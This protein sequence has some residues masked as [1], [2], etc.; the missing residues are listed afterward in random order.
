M[1]RRQLRPKPLLDEPSLRSFLVG[2]GVKPVHMS[3]IWRHMLANPDC[4]LDEIPGIPDRI[5]LPLKEEFTFL[6]STVATT[7]ES[8][9]DGTIKL[10][11][12]LQ[13][14]GEIE[15]VLIHHT[16]EAEDPAARQADRCG[17]RDTLCVSSQVGCRLGCTFCATGTMGLQGNLWAGEIQEQ[18]VHARRLRPVSNIVF[19]G[20]GEPLENY[21]G[22]VNAIRGLVDVQR[23]GVAPSSITVS[24]VGIVNNMRRFMDDL[25][26]IKLAISLHAP[27]QE[28]REQIVPVG[29]TFKLDALMEVLDEY[30]ERN[31]K[32]M[33]MVS[34]VLLAGVNDTDECAQQ[35]CELVKGRPVIVNLIPYNPFEENVYRYETPTDER[36][37]EFL[38][39]LSEAD[40]RVFQ[41]RHHGRDI[42][43][44]C[45]QL[46]KLGRQ[47]PV[48]DIENFTLEKERAPQA[49][50]RGPVASSRADRPRSSTS[51]G[52]H[53]T[54]LLALTAAVVCAA[55]AVV[56]ARWRGGG[57]R[58]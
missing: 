16:G 39:V 15:C 32:G 2:H 5:R 12:R 28:L 19:M 48:R 3:K 58:R 10:L 54:A 49:P 56:A 24:T 42:G 57:R 38:K 21:E 20:M 44:A 35:L 40:I 22:V 52:L 26:K 51:G 11:V 45:G 31:S 4:P 41:R 34:Y 6:T 37:D 18:L 36:V 29:K 55:V 30:A 25:P 43:A 9:I 46:A 14:G 17:Q 47:G 13:D 1:V 23:F 50:A 8:E 33:V 53:R 27:T 7:L